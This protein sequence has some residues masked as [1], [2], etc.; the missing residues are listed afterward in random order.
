MGGELVHLLKNHTM[1]VETF[2]FT[3][4]GQQF[5]QA[6]VKEQYACGTLSLHNLISALR[7]VRAKRERIDLY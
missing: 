7:M 5:Y 6:V 2:A 4:N 3:R 1:E